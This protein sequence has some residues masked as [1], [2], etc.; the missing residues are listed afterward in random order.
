MNSILYEP[1]YIVHIAWNIQYGTYDMG[2][3]CTHLGIHKFTHVTWAMFL[4]E[5]IL[6]LPLINIKLF[7]IIYLFGYNNKDQFF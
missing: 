1:Y 7:Y 4:F 2:L 5:K 3:S 6:Y